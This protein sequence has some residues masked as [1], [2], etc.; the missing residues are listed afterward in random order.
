[1][2]RINELM[3]EETSETTSTVNVIHAFSEKE[4]V[5]VNTPA[6]IQKYFEMGFVVGV[7]NWKA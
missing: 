3:S 7:Y 1:M 6:N 2:E 5:I 4:L